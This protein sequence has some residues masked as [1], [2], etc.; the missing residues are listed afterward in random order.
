MRPIETL[1]SANWEEKVVES[2][3]LILVDFEL[4]WCKTSFRQEIEEQDFQD[5]WGPMV[6]VGIVDVSRD[7]DIALCYRVQEL[8]TLALF[9][10]DKLLKAFTG[11][12][13]LQDMIRQ[14]FTFDGLMKIGILSEKS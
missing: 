4:P 10:G 11:S 3:T 5:K 1:T 13:R 7:V 6:R 9:D 2:A 8:P 14:I 12:M